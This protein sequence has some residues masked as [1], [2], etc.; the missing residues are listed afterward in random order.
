MECL[1]PI[2]EPVYQIIDSSVLEQELKAYAII[3]NPDIHILE[4]ELMFSNVFLFT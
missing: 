3:D 2:K 4:K 1:I